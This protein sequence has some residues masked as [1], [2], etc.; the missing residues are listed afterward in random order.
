MAIT[1]KLDPEQLQAIVGAI[2]NLSENLA[3]WEGNQNTA[4]EL[5][6]SDLI[7]TLGG[8]RSEDTQNRINEIA[9]TVRTVKERI[10]TSVNSQKENE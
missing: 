5:G 1:L 7:E 2:N 6:F 3:K 10:Q 4:L 8:S 9:S